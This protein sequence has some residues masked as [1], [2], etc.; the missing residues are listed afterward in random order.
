WKFG[1]FLL[2]LVCGVSLPSLSGLLVPPF[3]LIPTTWDWP[4][5]VTL[6]TA[7]LTLSLISNRRNASKKYCRVFFVFF[8][9]SLAI[10]LQALSGF[11]NFPST[12]VY[13]IALS[14]VSSTLLVTV[15]IIGLTLVSGEDLSSVFLA[16]GRLKFG[17]IVGLIG[18]TVFALVSIPAA[19]FLFQGRNLTVDRAL[20]WAAPILITVLLNGVREELLYRGLFFKKYESFLGSRPSNV[21][22]AIIFSLSHSV[23]GQGGS[24]YTQFIPILVVFTLGL[25]LVWG[26][27]MQK[28]NG[29]LGSVLFHA[30]SDIP[31]FLGIFSNLT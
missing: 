16:K 25:G 22:Q 17:L 2:L 4:Y 31:V 15:P 3:S 10:N 30:G 7:F 6:S 29:L 12:P 24:S 1:Q 11:L 20:G 27:L 26:L 23:A 28:T 13:N 14:M 9:A 21:L 5:R 8:I 19:T 18:F